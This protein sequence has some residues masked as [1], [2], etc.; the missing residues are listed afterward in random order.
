MSI[1]HDKHK[2]PRSSGAQCASFKIKIAVLKS[3]SVVVIHQKPSFE[4]KTRFQ[5]C[6]GSYCKI[7]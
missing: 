5:E 3:M 7:A 2:R 1:A 4:E 6:E